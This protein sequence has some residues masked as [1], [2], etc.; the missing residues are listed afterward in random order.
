MNCVWPEGTYGIPKP[1]TGCPE[2]WKSGY[3]NSNLH[4]RPVVVWLRD[5]PRDQRVDGSNPESTDFLTNSC[6]QATKALVSLFTKQ[7]K[8]VPAS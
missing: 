5:R 2:D 3:N 6:G 8:L 7:C 4:Y 1:D